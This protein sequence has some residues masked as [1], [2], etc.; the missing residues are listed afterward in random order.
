MRPGQQQNKRMRGRG[1]KGPNPLQRS[2][3][4]NGPDVKIRG[5]AQHIAEKYTTLARDA[6]ASGD[7]VMAENYLQHAEH[8]GRIVAAAQGSFQLQANDR[9]YDGDEDEME[10]GGEMAAPMP[11]QNGQNERPHGQNGQNG[12]SGQGGQNGHN[13][14][15]GYN[16]QNGRSD[17]GRDRRDERRNNF[18]ERQNGGEGQV[19]AGGEGGSQDARR[20]DENNFRRDRDDRRNRFEGRRERFNRDRGEGQGH[21]GPSDV[22][23]I[24]APQPDIAE[25]T[26]ADDASTQ[27]SADVRAD[28]GR[29]RGRPRREDAVDAP[30]EAAAVSA[31]PAVEPSAPA[32]VAAHEDAGDEKP[33]QRRRRAVKAVEGEAPAVEAAD[34]APKRK[35]PARPRRKKG[36]EDSA[37][38]ET[39]LPAFLVGSDS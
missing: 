22:A 10:E 17:H 9:D 34:A 27:P 33:A 3:E 11:Y 36:D 1:R 20:N 26:F 25:A 6:T 31:P 13:G 28:G 16:G 12:Q 18:R 2:Y 30:V 29:R 39:H 32:P 23:A 5:T 35:A 14:Q 4:S 38:G 21:S 19:E 37:E 7:R 15:G 8:Y 24:G